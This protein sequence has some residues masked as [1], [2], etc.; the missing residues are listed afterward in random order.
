LLRSKYFDI[1]RCFPKNQYST[2]ERLI[3]KLS[4]DVVCEVLSCTHP[5]TANKKILDH[6]IDKM[7]CK[8]DLLDFCNHL[9]NL[10]DSPIL[11]NALGELRKGIVLA[12]VETIKFLYHCR[13]SCT[14]TGWLKQ[15]IS[16]K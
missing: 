12:F 6:L 16:T 10:N 4:D 14:L 13:S 7:K 9:D 5:L 8:E 1:L 11:S 15:G 3:D 2:L